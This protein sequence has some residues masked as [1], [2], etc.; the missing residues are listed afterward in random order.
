MH[1]VPREDILVLL[2]SR[3]GVVDYFRNYDDFISR[4]TSSELT[5]CG[6]SFKD[7]NPNYGYPLNDPFFSQRYFKYIIKYETGEVID[8]V[9]AIRD[10]EE[11]RR[12]KYLN[13][14][15]FHR[16]RMFKY[17][18]GVVPYTRKRKASRN[19]FRH[20]KTTQERRWYRAWEDEG[21]KIRKR[22]SD[23]TLPNSWDDISKQYHKNWKHFRNHQWKYKI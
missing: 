1:I 9:Q 18:D 16:K 14:D 6:K 11:Y 8:P 2:V 13:C 21:I 19:Y 20:I 23:K 4:I 5:D 17:R 15:Y 3:E 7:R 22:R 10:K 12:N